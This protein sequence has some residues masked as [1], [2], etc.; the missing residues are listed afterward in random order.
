MKNILVISKAGECLMWWKSVKWEK[1]RWKL[2]KNI[3]YFCVDF[4]QL[5]G[6]PQKLLNAREMK[7]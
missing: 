4:Q 2:Q 1:R 7:I 5:L 3:P 6:D